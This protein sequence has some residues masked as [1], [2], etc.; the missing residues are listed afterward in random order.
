MSFLRK[1]GT[2]RD[3]TETW[4]RGHATVFFGRFLRGLSLGTSWDLWSKAAAVGATIDTDNGRITLMGAFPPI[5]LATHV[6]HEALFGWG[7]GNFLTTGGEPRSREVELRLYMDLPPTAEDFDIGLAWRLFVDA[8]GYS[9]KWPWW[10]DNSVSLRDV[11]ERVLRMEKVV[12]VLDSQAALVPLPEGTYTG[13][14][15]ISAEKNAGWWGH[16]SRETY[17]GFL[18]LDEPIT[19]EDGYGYNLF[20]FTD[21]RTPAE[22]VAKVIE[23]VLKRRGD[24]TVAPAERLRPENEEVH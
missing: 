18:E 7:L 1:P 2:F 24:T 12:R 6:H 13:K 8:S 19:D 20:H 9:S 4:L 17:K 23:T 14:V 21:I 5:M 10:A 11:L 22:M 16:L 3:G 15:T